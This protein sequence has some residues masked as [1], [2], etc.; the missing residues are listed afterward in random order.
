[1]K[2]YSFLIAFAL[3]VLALVWVAA[4]VAASH[5]LVLAMTVCIGAVYVFGAM[6]LRQ[7]R[8]TTQALNQALTSIPQDLSL[9]HI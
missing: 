2:R 5:P 9:I 1:M 3:G 6:E 8:A 4:S 7:Y